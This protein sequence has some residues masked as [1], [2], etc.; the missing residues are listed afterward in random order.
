[1]QATLFHVLSQESVGECAALF[2]RIKKYS[3]RHRYCA[4]NVIV[5]I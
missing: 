2:H 3:I 5:S 4:V 1:M